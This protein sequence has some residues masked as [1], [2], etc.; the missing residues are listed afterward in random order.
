MPHNEEGEYE[1]VLGNRQLLSIFF[2]VVLLLGAGF[3]MGYIMGRN[4][5]GAAPRELAVKKDA[6]E[7]AALEP[8]STAAPKPVAAEKEP[9]TPSAAPAETKPQPAAEDSKPSAAP[10]VEKKAETKAG[11]KADPPA[12]K[13][14]A[15]YREGK[16]PEGSLFIQVAAVSRAD[17]ETEATTLAKR[18]FKTWIA[19]NPNNAELF[20]VLV[21]PFDDT[22][23]LAKAKAQLEQL[24][25]KKAF[26][27]KF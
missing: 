5:A 4:S 6:V 20:S 7:S 23:E 17:A 10:E 13:G 3:T 27:K 21:G 18:E 15:L 16:P 12:R 2:I 19:P 24:G 9:E 22:G 14:A 8:P 25:F 1:L 26:R 11:K